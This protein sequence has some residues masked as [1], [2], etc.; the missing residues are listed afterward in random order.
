[1]EEHESEGPPLHKACRYVPKGMVFEPLWSV[2]G[3]NIDQ[4]VRDGVSVL[5]SGIAYDV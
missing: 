1:M 4:L 3:I 2:L 5:H